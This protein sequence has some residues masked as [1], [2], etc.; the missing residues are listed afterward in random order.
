MGMWR[1]MKKIKIVI[2]I[3]AIVILL[4]FSH[5][6]Y[7]IENYSSYDNSIDSGESEFLIKWREYSPPGS[8]EAEL[9]IYQ[10]GSL[11]YCS[12]DFYP[13]EYISDLNINVTLTSPGNLSVTILNESVIPD[14]FDLA[15]VDKFFSRY[16]TPTSKL[17]DYNGTIIIFEYLDEEL[18][19][20]TLELLKNTFEEHHFNSM[21]NWYKYQRPD[22]IQYDYV[23]STNIVYS[24]NNQT[25]QV[26]EYAND[27][28]DSL[29]NLQLEVKEIIGNDFS[30]P[31]DYSFFYEG[32]D[33]SLPRGFLVGQ[34]PQVC[35]II[36]LSIIEVILLN[37]YRK[38]K[39]WPL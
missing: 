37:Y 36:F 7:H 9:Q 33:R 15:K 8:N 5:F 10:N 16:D 30:I 39:Y 12:Y 26:I 32:Y 25:K 2:I 38:N 31:N 19:S 4:L 22:N 14:N 23:I 11:F 20:E 13:L 3:L 6:L 18:T 34:I 17:E 1:E 21:N 35:I 24:N 29:Q 28:P 27:G